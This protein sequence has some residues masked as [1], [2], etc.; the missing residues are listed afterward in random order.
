MWDEQY[1]KLIR[2][3]LPF[4]PADEALDPD[5]DLRDFGLDSLGIVDV[6]SA[7]ERTFQVRFTEDLL[8]ASTFR[9]PKVLW[10]AVDGLLAA[11]SS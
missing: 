9:T 2:Q 1:E 3:Y 5:T 11:A 6:L 10:A 4:L 7:L 8:N